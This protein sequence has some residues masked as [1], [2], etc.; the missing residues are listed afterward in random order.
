MEICEN[1]GLPIPMVPHLHQSKGYIKRKLRV[2]RA[3][4]C[5]ALVSAE[6][7][8]TSAGPQTTPFHGRQYTPRMEMCKTSGLPIPMV[9]RLQQRN[10]YIKRKLREWRAQ[11]YIALF[12]AETVLTSAGPQTTPF[13]GNGNMRNFGRTN[14]HGTAFPQEECSYQKEATG[15]QNPKQNPKMYCSSSWKNPTYLCGSAKYPVSW[16]V[17]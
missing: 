8:L 12:G 4:K 11:K 6:T 3:Q 9:P 7:V 15:T 1:S 10:G 5:N 16:V 2:W 14:R 17:V 13:P